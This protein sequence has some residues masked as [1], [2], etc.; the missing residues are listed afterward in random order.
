MNMG[1][2]L[3][4]KALVEPRCN[5]FLLTLQYSGECIVQLD[6]QGRI[7]C[8]SV[9]LVKRQIFQLKQFDIMRN[10]VYYISPKDRCPNTVYLMR[11]T[12]RNSYLSKSLRIWGYL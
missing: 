11:K 3:H 9:N 4:N 5:I 10:L 6:Q 2:G 7:K 1:L 8:L 12:L